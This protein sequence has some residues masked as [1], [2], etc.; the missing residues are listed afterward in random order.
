V[1]TRVVATESGVGEIL[2]ADALV[3]VEVDSRSIA[4]GIE[5]ALGREGTPTYDRRTWDQVVE[6]TIDY[7]E[8]VAAGEA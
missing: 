7:Y 8:R 5:E 1:G 4:D 3:E 2:S 6:E